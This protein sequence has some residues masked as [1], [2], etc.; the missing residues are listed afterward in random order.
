MAKQTD[1]LLK[2]V[3]PLV[4]NSI[5]KN[6]K[7]YKECITRFMSARNTSLFDTAPCDRIYFG[8]N[9]LDDFWI[10]M[11]LSEK[12]IIEGLSQTY[13]WSIGAFNPRAAKDPFTVAVLMIIRYFFLKK[14][15]KNLELSMIY[16]AFSGKF[17]PS[18]HYAMFKKV[19]PS[20]YRHVMDY[21]VNTELTKKYDLKSQGHVLGVIRSI[22]ATWIDSYAQRMK[23]MEDEDAVY[24][25]QQLHNRIKSFMKNIASLY[26]KAYENKD[27]LT[28]DSEDHSNISNS[29]RLVGSDSLKAQKFIDKSMQKILSSDVDYKLCKMASN[30]N[31]KTEEVKS[32]MQTVLSGENAIAEVKELISLMVYN[33]FEQSKTKDVADISFIN[34]SIA[35]KPNAKDENIIRQKEIIEKWLMEGSPAYH[36]RKSRIATKNDYY[37]ALYIYIALLIH[38]SNK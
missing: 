36:K 37:R 22:A 10:S 34:Y 19:Q 20:Q 25:I 18:I 13:Y 32:I 3:Y 5:Q 9:D 14:D 29:Y 27:Y 6:E 16:L 15:Q 11:K 8:Q 24:L 33:Y 30:S 1:A 35:L 12:Q 21:V 23:S 17:Y 31:V 28:F 2:H 7:Q 38:N 26:Y 4:A